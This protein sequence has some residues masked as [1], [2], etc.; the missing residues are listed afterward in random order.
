M[1]P[2]PLSGLI[3][4]IP[5][6]EAI[7]ARQRDRLDPSA[8]LDVPAHITVLFPFMPPGEIGAPV[9]AA[10]G[11]LFAAVPRFRFRLDRTAWFADRVLYLAPLDPAPFA[12][13]TDR[14]VA[15]YPAYLPY[16]GQFA[17][18]VPHLTVAE[19]QA[20]SGLSPA[21]LSAADLGAAEAAVAPLLPVDGEVT[22]VTLIA[23]HEA[24]GPFAALAVFPL[25]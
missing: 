25:G 14:V 21:D 12:A 7:V 11:R 18:V 20:A 17:E 13:L 2:S 22:A 6:A 9:L 8:G 10:L 15:A 1:A 4:P 16:Q 24:D 3:V 23:Q 19:R 5:E